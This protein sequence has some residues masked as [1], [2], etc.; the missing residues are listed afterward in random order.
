MVLLVGVISNYIYVLAVY[1]EPLHDAHGWS[2]N[3]IVLAYS[4]T[5]FCEIPAYVIGGWLSKRFGMKRILVVSGVLYGLA[6]LASGLTSSVTAF[7]VT[8]GFIASLAMFGVYIATLALINV[9]FPNRKGLVMGILYGSQAIGGAVMAPMANYFIEIFDV[10]WALIWQGAVFTVI[11]F[12]SC[13]LVTDPTKGDAR[14]M[15]EIQEEAERKEIEDAMEGRGE[16]ARPTMKWK[17]AF[18]HPA[19]WLFFVSLVFIQLIGNLLVTDI[20]YLA[21]NN[22]GVSNADAAWVI[23]AFSI[24]AGAGGVVIGY[25]SDRIGPYR[26]TF[27][28]GIV[29]GALLLLLILIGRDS[30][31]LF[32]I[33][34]VI[35]GFTYNGMTTLNPVMIMDSYSSDDFGI[36]MGG[37]AVAYTI[38]GLAGPQIGLEFAFVPMIIICAALSIIGGWFARASGRSLN[39]YYRSVDSKC[40]VR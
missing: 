33:M 35:Q 3:S 28:L 7:V 30:F 37:M 17:K 11:M 36:V 14:A 34:C 18:T 16:D 21:E 5:I 22:Y 31:M 40:E 27:W 4:A 9:L 1:V 19:F 15:S 23:S 8:Q 2:R 24:A 26:A 13:M 20:P 38:V 39:R 25:I 12:I 32:G 6:I 10:S 29:D